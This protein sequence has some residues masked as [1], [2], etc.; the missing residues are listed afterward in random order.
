MQIFRAAI[1]CLKLEK[2]SP[3]SVLLVVNF[4]HCVTS[5]NRKL[6]ALPLPVCHSINFTTLRPKSRQISPLCDVIN[7]Q[8]FRAPV[9]YLKFAKFSPNSVPLAVKCCSCVTSAKQPRYF[10]R[11]SIVYLTLENN[12]QISVVFVV[13][14]RHCVTSSN[15]KFFELT[16]SIWNSQN[17]YQTFSH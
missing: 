5:S 9:V 11:A 15:H 6:F 2:F 14:F 17:F 7:T 10:F 8:I 12:S 16:F 4:R 1:V 13:N 3:I